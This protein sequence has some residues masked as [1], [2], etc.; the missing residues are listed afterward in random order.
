MLSGG[1]VLLAL[2]AGI[3]AQGCGR[4]PIAPNMN[5]N[6]ERDINNEIVGGVNAVPNSWPWQVVWCV[7]ANP[8]SCSLSCGGSVIHNNWIITAGHCVY[9]NTNNPGRFLVKAGVFDYA[10]STEASMQAVGVKNIFLHPSY[11]Q[12]G[13]PRF[14]I[15]VVE[16][17]TSLQYTN[18]VQPVCLPSADSTQTSPPSSAWVTGWGTTTVGGGGSVSRQLKQVNVPFVT[19]AS[20]RNSYSTNVDDSQMTC[21]GVTGKDSCQGDS[22]GPLVGLSNNGSWFEYGIV[23]WGQGCANAGYPG[24]YARTSAFCTWINQATRGDVNCARPT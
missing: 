14:D 8:A 1:L 9:G 7:G 11:T 17:T 3:Q 2:V 15:A 5:N 20:C 21:A 4:T 22:G 24:V 19:Y 6:G 12:S 13:V 23:S 16:L 18:Q 10:T